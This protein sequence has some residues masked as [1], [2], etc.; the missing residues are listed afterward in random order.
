MAKL[1]RKKDFKVGLH[2]RIFLNINTG[3][4]TQILAVFYCVY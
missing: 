1:S 2:G 4:G 3:F